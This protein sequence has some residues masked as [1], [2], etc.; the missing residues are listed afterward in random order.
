MKGWY[1]VDQFR[2]ETIMFLYIVNIALWTLG[3]DLGGLGR[4]G[5]WGAGIGGKGD[6]RVYS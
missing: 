6:T 3:V 2:R 1:K 5:E 4:G